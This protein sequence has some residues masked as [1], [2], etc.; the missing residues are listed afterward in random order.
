MFK[1]NANSSV[2]ITIAVRLCLLAQK[3]ERKTIT[4]HSLRK[5]SR[6]RNKYHEN[7]AHET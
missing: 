4:T 7:K 6:S 3:Q 5:S 1:V 2:S